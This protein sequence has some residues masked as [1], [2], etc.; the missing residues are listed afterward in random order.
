M[1]FLALHSHFLERCVPI[2]ASTDTGT[3]CSSV[4]DAFSLTHFMDARVESTS[5]T[6]LGPR[7]SSTLLLGSCVLG[8][9]FFVSTYNTVNRLY[10]H[11]PQ[12]ILRHI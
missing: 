5:S 6:W 10:H 9:F 2:F 7:K 11:S 3:D 8:H 1:V 4:M 12:R